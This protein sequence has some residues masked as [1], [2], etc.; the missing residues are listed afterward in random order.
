MAPHKGRG[1]EEVKRKKVVKGRGESKG[2][3]DQSMS[4]VLLKGYEIR[5][6]GSDGVSNWVVFDW[7][8]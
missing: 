5:S 4:K 8:G 2:P 3:L 1:V 7:Q 6:E